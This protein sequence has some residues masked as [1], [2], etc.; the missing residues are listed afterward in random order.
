LVRFSGKVRVPE[1]AGPGKATIR[2]TIPG[3]K[4]KAVRPSAIEVPL[5]EPHKNGAARSGM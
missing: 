5:V 1:E 2:L 3:W 4:G